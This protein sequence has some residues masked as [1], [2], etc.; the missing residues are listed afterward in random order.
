MPPEHLL[1]PVIEK[2]KYFNLNDEIA[3]LYQN[4]LTEAFNKDKCNNVHPAF[5]DIINQLSPDEA[6]ILSFFDNKKTD[7]NE[8]GT[9]VFEIPDLVNNKYC[10]RLIN[11]YDEKETK[12]YYSTNKEGVINEWTTRTSKN[13]EKI[14]SWNTKNKDK[15]NLMPI[16]LLT[17][18][19]QSKMYISH[20]TSL[21]IIE[22][23]RLDPVNITFFSEYDWFYKKLMLGDV[24]FKTAIKSKIYK[25]TE[26]GELFFDVCITNTKI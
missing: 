16:H 12:V 10:R 8:V 13:I 5:I 4:L 7:R 14:V 11:L 22:I 23:S 3:K 9:L 20:L 1:F 15:F 19:K 17:N 6:K 18:V 2:L 25:L 21:N 26:F 24:I